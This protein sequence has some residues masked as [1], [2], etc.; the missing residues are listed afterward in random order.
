MSKAELIDEK[1]FQTDPLYR[2]NPLGVC[3]AKFN[4]RLLSY[5]DEET[6]ARRAAFAEDARGRLVATDAAGNAFI[7]P[8]VVSLQDSLDALT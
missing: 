4:N 3:M 5:F 2:D 7:L 8:E 6:Q 1:S